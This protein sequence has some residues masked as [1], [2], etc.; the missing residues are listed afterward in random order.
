LVAATAPV[1]DTLCGATYLLAKNREKLVKLQQEVDSLTHPEYIT[2]S[3]TAKMPYLLAVINESLR[4]YTPTPGGGRRQA[5]PEGAMVSGR[6]IPGGVSFS[7]CVV[8]KCI[9]TLHF[10]RQLCVYQLPAFTL[11]NNFALPDTFLPE[12]WLPA[13][14]PDRPKATL[15]DKQEVFQPF[16][17]GPK[18]CLGKG[19][20]Y[21]EIKLILARLIWHFD[22]ELVDDGFAFEKQKAY[23]F[24]ERPPLNVRLSLRKH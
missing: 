12:R 15:S 8:P 3:S 16:S 19:L 21:A 10:R 11:P 1:S 5:P 17:V 9:L 6:Y 4:C 23:L 7:R 18:A 22:F 24:R 13:S 2:M 20:A 14:H